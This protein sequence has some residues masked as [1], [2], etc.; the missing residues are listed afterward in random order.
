MALNEC[1][2]G[3][4]GPH[5]GRSQAKWASR[6]A[7]IVDHVAPA[8]AQPAHAETTPTQG[9]EEPAS[10]VAPGIS[11]CL[12]AVALPPD[13]AALDGRLSLIISPAGAV[14]EP[15]LHVASDRCE[16]DAVTRTS[17]DSSL[18]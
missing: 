7:N 2:C 10:G 16:C 1:S 9:A 3:C 13:T 6:L 8:R 17:A 12:D 5:D 15:R 14:P 4:D 18:T 11:I